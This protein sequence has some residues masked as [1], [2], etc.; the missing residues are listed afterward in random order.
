[1]LLKEDGIV[2]DGKHLREPTSNHS[3]LSCHPED[4][5]E[6]ILLKENGNKFFLLSS[7]YVCMA[8]NNIIY[9]L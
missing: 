9:H 6:Q 5:Y 3:L 2:G 8:I 1:M 4:K 7:V